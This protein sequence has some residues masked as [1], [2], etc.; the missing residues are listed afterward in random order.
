MS[1]WLTIGIMLAV[2]IPG[3]AVAQQRTPNLGKSG[4]IR[5]WP[6]VGVWETFLTRAG[7]SQLQCIAGTGVFTDPPDYYGWGWKDLNGQFTLFIFDT[8][9]N[10]VSGGS[11]SLFIDDVKVGQF[12]IT[13]R[14]NTGQ[15]FAVV[16][17]IPDAKVDAIKGLIQSGAS[18]KFVTENQTYSAPLQGSEQVMGYFSD[19]I[20]HAQ[21]LNAMQGSAAVPN[22]TAA[23]SATSVPPNAP[24]PTETQSQAT[25]VAPSST[26]RTARTQ[27]GRA[28]DLHFGPSFPCPSP[29][30]PLAQ[31]VCSSPELSDADLRYVQAYQALRAQLGP[32]G[33][34]T[35][36]QDADAFVRTVRAQCGIGA[37][38]TGMIASP[39]AVPCVLQHYL[40][41]RNLLASRLTGPAA[42]EAA[43]PLP[44]HVALQANLMALGFLKPDAVIDGVYGPATRTAILEWQ[45]SRGRPLTGF[46]S[47]SDSV[48]LEQQA[49]VPRS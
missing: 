38:D 12:K 4:M 16:A 43:R 11:I 27:Y 29:R 25:N 9:Q 13:E 44:T 36:R 37:P 3:L 14:Y 28:A 20:A 15:T 10:A 21:R 22:P 31:L 1:R 30:D 41:Q 33:Q 42:E 19:C 45:Q 48:L 7:T 49:A 5:T 2:A 6:R 46:L 18:I 17:A 35:L 23:P 40:S 24:T 34:K 47:N 32:S 8:E 39:A 26:G